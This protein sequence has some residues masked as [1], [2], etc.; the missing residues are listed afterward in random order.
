[1]LNHDDNIII[2]TY[3]PILY[4]CYIVARREDCP[5]ELLNGLCKSYYTYI[6]EYIYYYVDVSRSVHDVYK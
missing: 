4:L 6:Q 1:M 3:I 5:R 2:A